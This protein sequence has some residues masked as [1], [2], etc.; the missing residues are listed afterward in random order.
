MT[1]VGLFQHPAR[2]LR[3]LRGRQGELRGR[4]GRRRPSIR[5]LPVPQGRHRRV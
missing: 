5:L 4:A 1:A 2:A 3:F